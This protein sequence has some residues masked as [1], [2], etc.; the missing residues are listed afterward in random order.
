MARPLNVLFLCTHNSARSVLAECLLNHLGGARFRAFSAGSQPS[1]RVNPFA[2]QALAEQGIDTTGVR[3]KAWDE[4]AAPGA[5]AMDLIITVCDSAAG[6]TC[7]VWPGHPAT[8]HWGY[9]DPSATPGSDAAK[10]TA[11]RD[12]LALIRR[13]LEILVAMPDERLHALALQQTARDLAAH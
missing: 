11:F 4:F 9:A 7:P 3:S 12:T 5:P 1:G 2:L 10:L 6:E 13:R 8:A